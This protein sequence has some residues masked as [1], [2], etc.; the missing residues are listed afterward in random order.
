MGS[1]R[2]IFLAAFCIL[3][4]G[5]ARAEQFSIK[6][7]REFTYFLTFDTTANRAVY[8]VVQDG[9]Y[10]GHMQRASAGRIEFDLDGHGGGLRKLVWESEKKKVTWLPGAPGD[11]TRSLIVN[12]CMSTDLRDVLSR[13]EQIFPYGK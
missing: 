6:C 3:H 12:D 1:F 7:H 5:A 10:K 4:I 8:E 11:K 2:Q 13:Y 9:T